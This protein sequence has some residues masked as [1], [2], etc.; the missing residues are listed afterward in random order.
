MSSHSDNPGDF[1]SREYDYVVVGGG[2]AG[3]V[4]AARLSEDPH[5]KVAVIEAGPA[6]FD[7][8]LIN[9]PYRFGQSI[10][11]KYDWQ[12]ETVPQP[13][14]ADR[15][16]PW[17]R[18]KVLGGTS[19]L[20]F[21]AWTRGHKEDYDAWVEMGN[22][23]WGWDD[24]LFVMAGCSR[25]Y[26][27]K[28]ETFYAPTRAVQDEHLSF[29][30]AAWHGIDGPMKTSHALEYSP[31]L[32]YWHR[33]LENLGIETSPDSLSGANAEAV[34]NEI[35]LEKE[36]GEWTAKGVRVKC[37]GEEFIVKASKEVIISAGSVQSP[38]LLELSGIGN[39]KILEVAGIQTKVCN[40]N[41][42]ENLQDHLCKSVPYQAGQ[43]VPDH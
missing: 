40:P 26:F 38:Q 37:G 39:P 14:L 43:G 36:D 19:A 28:S 1:A 27:K 23:G 41:V 4:V 20:N 33:T 24:L 31:S 25:P 35:L 21:M 15:K 6:A 29:F 22:K 3:L 16:L 2:T 42:G 9:D 5:L 13:G 18:G 7:E 8:P 11:T 34:T 30:E 10:G 17:P 12:F 32:K